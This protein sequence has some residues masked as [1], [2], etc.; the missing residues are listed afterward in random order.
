MDRMLNV[1][2][3]ATAY[4]MAT[5]D[6]ESLRDDLEL[7]AAETGPGNIQTQVVLE[8]AL[9]TL[10]EEL[11]DAIELLRY[12]EECVLAH[13]TVIRIPVRREITQALSWLEHLTECYPPLPDR[14]VE[15][16]VKEW[17]E[18]ALAWEGA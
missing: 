10:L 7:L 11:E 4:L 2:A 14:F 1:T 17:T 15:L 18:H 5:S 3:V 13:G 12:S 16:Q 6:D 9:L 8:I